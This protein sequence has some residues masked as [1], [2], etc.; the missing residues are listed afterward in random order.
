MINGL[1]LRGQTSHNLLVNLFKGY[2][3]CSDHEFVAYIKCKQD[4]FEEGNPIQVDNLMKNAADKYKT[5]L[6][7]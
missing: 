4:S 2:M 5:M 7:K 1:R 3:A 6:L